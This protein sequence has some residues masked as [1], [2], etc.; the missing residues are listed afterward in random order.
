M[1]ESGSLCGVTWQNAVLCRDIGSAYVTTIYFKTLWSTV[2][3][4]SL[5]GGPRHHIF[6]IK[7][8]SSLIIDVNC[9]STTGVLDA[10]CGVA[11]LGHW[12]W[13]L[14]WRVVH[15]AFVQLCMEW[16][17]VLLV[18]LVSSLVEPW[19]ALLYMCWRLWTLYSAL[20]A[21]NWY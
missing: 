12:W 8:S 13:L 6:L 10:P 7:H 14:K 3:N 17:L 4:H 21:G 1:T 20:S 9:W 18:H 15:K 16:Q 19:M 5:E 2:R 11:G